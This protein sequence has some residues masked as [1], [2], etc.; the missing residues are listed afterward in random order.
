MVYWK[1]DFSEEEMNTFV[2]EIRLEY[3]NR[4]VLHSHHH[5]AKALVIHRIHFTENNRNAVTKTI[6][7]LQETRFH[8]VDFYAFHRRF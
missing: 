2:T 8:S 4:L 7:N 3:R 5:L 6:R 1:P